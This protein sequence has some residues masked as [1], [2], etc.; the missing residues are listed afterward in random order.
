MMRYLPTLALVLVTAIP[1]SA[2]NSTTW[3]GVELGSPTG[4][5]VYL[6]R[7]SAA[8]ISILAAWDLDDFLFLNA[9]WML[10]EEITIEDRLS[11]FWGPGV[12]VG[13]RDNDRSNDGAALGASLRGGI[14][15]GWSRLVG[16]AH[17]TPR[18]E[19]IPETD[20]GM[21]GGIGLRMRL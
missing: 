9:H 13:I 21:G 16:Y 17:L 5:A 1:A 19:L 8:D 18:F 10:G 11:W 20:F 4:L 6:E 3:L 14:Q 15:Y 12:F 2:Q 7:P